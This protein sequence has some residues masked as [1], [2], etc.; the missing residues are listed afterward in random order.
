MI[1]GVE[2]SASPDLV[3]RLV[4][5]HKLNGHLTSPEA[6]ALLRREGVTH[7]YIGQRGGPIVLDE[8]LNSPAFE[9][10]YQHGAAHVFRLE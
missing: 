8:L 6:L 2:R 1:Y 7:V 10:E 4:A 9:L 3:A 5:L